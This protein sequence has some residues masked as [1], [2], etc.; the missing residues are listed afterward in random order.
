MK[1]SN[2]KTIKTVC[3]EAGAVANLGHQAITIEMCEGIAWITQN[4]YD[5]FLDP[6]QKIELEATRHPIVVSSHNKNEPI[7]FKYHGHELIDSP[8]HE[9]NIPSNFGAGNL[10]TSV[11]SMIRG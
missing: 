7:V 2:N 4:G 8:E 9:V 6:G 3:L 5:T 11:L 1:R 10:V